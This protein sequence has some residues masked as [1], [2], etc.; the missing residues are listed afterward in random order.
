MSLPR[1]GVRVG[2]A[3]LAFA[4]AGPFLAAYTVFVYVP[5]AREVEIVRVQR[6]MAT[7]DLE[8]LLHVARGFPEFEEAEKR[9]KDRL[10]DLAQLVPDEAAPQAFASRVAELGHASGLTLD[11]LKDATS[12]R[13]DFYDVVRVRVEM[14][15]SF[16]ALV[17]FGDRV[18]QERRLTAVRRWSIGR[19]QG[20]HYRAEALVEGYAYAIPQGR[21]RRY[22]Q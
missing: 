13:R 1:R 8:R 4:L 17:D 7:R 19:V 20:A 10:S 6:D 22:G 2:N 5:M 9:M 3:T 14:Q 16:A 11:G 15:G 21:K 12:D 18:S